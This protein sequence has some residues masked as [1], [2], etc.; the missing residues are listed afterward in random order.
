MF[1][2]GWNFISFV[3]VFRSSCTLT[4]LWPLALTETVG[5]ILYNPFKH[6]KGMFSAALL[7]SWKA[8]CY[9]E[10][11]EYPACPAKLIVFATSPGKEDVLLHGS[12]PLYSPLLSIRSYWTEPM[13]YSLILDQTRGS[14]VLA[15]L[16]W[17]LSA[18]SV[19]IQQQPCLLP[20]TY[21]LPR[22]VFSHS[23]QRLHLKTPWGLLFFNLIKCQVFGSGE[24]PTR[25]FRLDSLS[26]VIFSHCNFWIRWNVSQVCRGNVIKDELRQAPNWPGEWQERWTESCWWVTPWGS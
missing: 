11:P 26:C 18:P 15:N 10:G 16:D 17:K 8:W 13:A 23:R 12:H 25:S 7:L 20:V 2:E 22:I 1:Q 9:K 4:F 24:L 19:C 6:P 21:P 14:F 3:S 5:E